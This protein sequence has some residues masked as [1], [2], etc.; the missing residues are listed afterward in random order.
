[1]GG[2]R[3][4]FLFFFTRNETACWSF[5]G[6]R[7]LLLWQPD[8]RVPLCNTT[9]APSEP[10]PRVSGGLLSS[11]HFDRTSYLQRRAKK[12]LTQRMHLRFRNA[13][14]GEF[15][16]KTKTKKQW[17]VRAPWKAGSAGQDILHEEAQI[18][19]KEIRIHLSYV[20]DE[21]NQ[22]E[23]PRPHTGT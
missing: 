19:S 13:Q 15:C 4:A 16:Q 6:C 12:N 17:S 8:A 20:L 7:L 10:F 3:N 1:M 14:T 5:S 18:W 22:K 2:F 9:L 23:K 21:V 11:G